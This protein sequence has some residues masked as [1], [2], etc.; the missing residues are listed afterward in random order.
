M[1]KI[2]A[3]KERKTLHQKE[4]N[5]KKQAVKDQKEAEEWSLGAKDASKKEAQR[6]KKEAQLAKKNEAAQLLEQEEKE[7]SKFKPLLKP[8][9]KSGEDVSTKRSQKVEQESTERKEIPVYSASNIDDALDLLA[10]ATE[11]S[12][13]SGGGK[14]GLSNSVPISAANIERHPERRFKAAFRAYEE[15]ELAKLKE[16]NPGLRYTQLHNILFENFK[17]SPENPFNQA[18]VLRHNATKE[19]SDKMIEAARQDIENRLRV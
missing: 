16:E 12:S 7:L 6:L 18:N 14:T 8:T 15:R 4:I 11:T 5:A 10:I 1:Y 2:T 9:K 17:K 19:E 3:A 13:S